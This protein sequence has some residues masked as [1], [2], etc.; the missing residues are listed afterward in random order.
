MVDN[1]AAE[2]IKLFDEWDQIDKNTLADR[3]E[4]VLYKKYPECEA[5]WLNKIGHLSQMTGAKPDTVYAWFNRG[6]GNVKVP[7]LQ[8]CRIALA[9]NLDV[10]TFLFSDN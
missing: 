2:I 9:M 7:F 1:V 3:V 10:D 8:L 4:T 6:R 5:S